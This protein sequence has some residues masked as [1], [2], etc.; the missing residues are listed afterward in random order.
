VARIT[1]TVMAS[2]EHSGSAGFVRLAVLEDGR[3]VVI[4]S[5]HTA[6]RTDTPDTLARYTLEEAQS[7]QRQ[8]ELGIGPRF[9]GVVRDGDRWA[10]VMDIVPGDFVGTPINART[11][12][13]AETII[14]RLRNGGYEDLGDFQKYRTQQGRLLSI[15][16]G[17]VAA[18]QGRPDRCMSPNSGGGSYTSIRL[19][20][21][22]EADAAVGIP[23]LENL[24]RTNPEA[25]TGLIEKM[26]S[27][28]HRND[29]WA[30]RLRQR[31]GDYLR[32]HLPGA[33]P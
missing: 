10:V 16:A 3:P 21:I 30:V 31:Y 25:F 2:D 26:N 33:R 11:F 19:P 1:N 8:D 12:Q 13:D 23:Y 22:A 9:H 4:K 28:N 29:P 27:Y 14:G 15:D 32:Q 24:R 6:N 20:L 18:A 17:R 5:Y 7:L